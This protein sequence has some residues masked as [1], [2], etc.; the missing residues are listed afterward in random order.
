M[1]ILTNH[2]ALC[3]E[4]VY[5]RESVLPVKA[6]AHLSHYLVDSVLFEELDVYGTHFPILVS[7]IP[8]LAGTDLTQPP[9]GLELLCPLGDPSNLGAVTRSCLAFGVRNLILL[10]E[11]VH[12]FHPKAIR[13]SC[14][15]VFE[16]L[17][18]HGPALADLEG[19]RILRWIVALDFNGEDLITW[20][21]PVDVRLLI[22]EEGPGQP[23]HP[24]FQKIT[25]PQSKEANSL[26]AAAATSIALF[27]YRQQHSL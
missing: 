16:Q 12:P 23:S 18:S 21:W 1:E 3:L 10:K 4:L 14:G 20:R 25:I 24:G 2:P 8:K 13:S 6:P 22:G 19:E 11:A 9:V 5:P 7:R 17:M 26:N 27:S 15:A